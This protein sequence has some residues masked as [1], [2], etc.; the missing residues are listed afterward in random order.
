MEHSFVVAL[1][2]KMCYKIMSNFIQPHKRKGKK[3]GERVEEG[4]G[5]VSKE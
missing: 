2:K 1:N 5:G 3:G 4:E